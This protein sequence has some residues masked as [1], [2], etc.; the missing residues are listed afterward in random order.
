MIEWG[1]LMEEL[2]P[3]DRTAVK[4]EKDPSRGFDYR[5]ITIEQIP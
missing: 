3:E 4:I 1:N 5:R 2:R